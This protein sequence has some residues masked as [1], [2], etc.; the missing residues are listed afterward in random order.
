MS[1]FYQ[2]FLLRAWMFDMWRVRFRW[3][4]KGSR[5]PIKGHKTLG[6]AKRGLLKGFRCSHLFSLIYLFFSSIFSSFWIMSLFVFH[7]E[8]WI[9]GVETS[10]ELICCELL[11]GTLSFL[12]LVIFV[13]LISF[14]FFFVLACCIFVSCTKKT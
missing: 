4:K 11:V 5:K 7:L 13:F 2:H 3:R 10:F 12:H 9:E 6:R 1:S 8:L 14:F